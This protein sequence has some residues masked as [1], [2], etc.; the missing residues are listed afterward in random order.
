MVNLGGVRLKSDSNKKKF[1]ETIWF[2]KLMSLSVLHEFPLGSVLMVITVQ[3]HVYPG[4]GMGLG[5]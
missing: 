1:D 4:I 3:V 2:D 5:S